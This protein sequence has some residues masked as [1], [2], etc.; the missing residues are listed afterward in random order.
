LDG[1]TAT[2]DLEANGD[3]NYDAITNWLL[4]VYKQTGTVDEYVSM[5]ARSGLKANI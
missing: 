5:L 3:V 1:T 2:I 4:D